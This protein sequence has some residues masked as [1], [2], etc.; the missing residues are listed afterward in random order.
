MKIL[1]DVRDQLVNMDAI[2]AQVISGSPTQPLQEAN[3]RLRIVLASWYGIVKGRGV[4]AISKWI[5]NTL[6]FNPTEVAEKILVDAMIDPELAIKMLQE[7]LP[8]NAVPLS[9]W[10]KT[11]ILNNVLADLARK[12]AE[13]KDKIISQQEEQQ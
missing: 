6:G 13:L 2:N 5:S 4:F 11:Y 7:D 1:K 9:K 12:P 3:N 10:F 8:K